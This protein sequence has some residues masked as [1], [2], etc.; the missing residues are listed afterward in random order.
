MINYLQR[1]A[2]QDRLDTAIYALL[3]D[4]VALSS[5]AEGNGLGKH[6]CDYFATALLVHIIFLRDACVET[7]NL[8]RQRGD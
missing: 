1:G 7:Q 2:P 4:Y 8:L 6:D 5:A 3:G